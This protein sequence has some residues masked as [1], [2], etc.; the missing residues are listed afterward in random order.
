[1]GQQQSSRQFLHARY[2]HCPVSFVWERR[3]YLSLPVEVRRP[4]YLL[5]NYHKSM[6]LRVVLPTMQVGLLFPSRT[7]I[8]EKKRPARPFLQNFWSPGQRFPAY[9][10][11]RDIAPHLLTVLHLSLLHQLPLVLH[12]CSCCFFQYLARGM[13]RIRT[14][15]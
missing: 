14:P 1:M 3:G 2:T 7:K 10:N 9:Q 5:F 13:M 12:D 6:L 8:T 15:T 11:F 4:V